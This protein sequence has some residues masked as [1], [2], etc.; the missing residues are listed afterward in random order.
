MEDERMAAE[1]AMVDDWLGADPSTSQAGAPTAG[2]A[3]ATVEPATGLE[4]NMALKNGVGEPDDHRGD[5]DRE[6]AAMMHAT[7]TK[8]RDRLDMDPDEVL[9]ILLGT[10][11]GSDPRTA[12]DEPTAAVAPVPPAPVLPV[13]PPPMPLVAP[14]PSVVPPAPTPPGLFAATPPG[15]APATAAPPPG[16]FATG[17]GPEQATVPGVG[18]QPPAPQIVTPPPAPHIAT[19]PPPPGTDAGLVRAPLF[20]A[21]PEAEPAGPLPDTPA[22]PS[23]A[24]LFTEILSATP[25]SS[26]IEAEPEPH[27]PGSVTQDMTIVAKRRKRFRLR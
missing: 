5:P 3:P 4:T 1:Q 18:A 16:L 26:P 25:D 20:Y 14:P 21:P 10:P 17:A 13:P 19:P 9:D 7:K 11:T 2:P 24:S 15:S 8:K 22:Q 6:G 27:D 12:T 23:A